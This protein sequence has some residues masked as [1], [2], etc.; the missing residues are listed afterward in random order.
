MYYVSS[1]GLFPNS[2]NLIYDNVLYNDTPATHYQ[3]SDERVNIY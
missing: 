2:F 3:N 1:I